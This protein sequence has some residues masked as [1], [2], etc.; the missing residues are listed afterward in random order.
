MVVA[1]A[2]AKQVYHIKSDQK[3]TE[4][5]GLPF[6]Q[7]ICDENTIRDLCQQGIDYNALEFLGTIAKQSAYS[8]LIN[9]IIAISHRIL[10][11]KEEY[12]RFCKENQISDEATLKAVLKQKSL[13]DYLLGD[14]KLSEV[15]TRKILLVSN[16]VAS[17]ANV[18]YVAI[19]GGVSAYGGDA[20]GLYR[21]LGKLD[22]GGILV[23]LRHLLSDSLIIT[24][25]KDDFIKSEISKDFQKRLAEVQ[26][27][28]L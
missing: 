14:K 21:T 3:S 24:K 18:V 19:A 7:L 25:I 6:L 20:E 8:E 4:G 13:H 15:R 1:A 9:F 2:G 12:D 26:E 11:A 10:I 28:A 23:T 16:A 17:S 5:I 22:I 27:S